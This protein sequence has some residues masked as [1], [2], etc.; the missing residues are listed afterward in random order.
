MQEE[1]EKTLT[2]L[3]MK[4]DIV[5]KKMNSKKKSDRVRWY[6]EYLII[7]REI[8]YLERQ[9]E[10][11]KQMIQEIENKEKPEVILIK[12]EQKKE[13]FWKRLFSS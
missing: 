9:V 11:L 6:K 5:L 3:N 10:I 8:I 4:K 2:V 7:K 12:E 1:L 13:G